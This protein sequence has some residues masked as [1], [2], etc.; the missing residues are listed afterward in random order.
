M[1]YSIT[2]SLTASVLGN[3]KRNFPG[4]DLKSIVIQIMIAVAVVA[5]TRKLCKAADQFQ[6]NTAL[7]S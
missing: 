4:I 2:G 6:K 7:Y 1:D 5:D 3:I